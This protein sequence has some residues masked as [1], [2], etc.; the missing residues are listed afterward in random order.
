[1]RRQ[2]I[3]LPPRV[4]LR[5]KKRGRPPGH[6]GERSTYEDSQDNDIRHQEEFR[7]DDFVEIIRSHRGQIRKP[8]SLEEAICFLGLRTI[9]VRPLD[10]AM[11]WKRYRLEREADVPLLSFGSMQYVGFRTES[12]AVMW[13]VNK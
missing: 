1:M 12:A 13:E 7:Q 4:R 5:G 6:S 10:G 8:I 2:D 3:D 9:I 11:L